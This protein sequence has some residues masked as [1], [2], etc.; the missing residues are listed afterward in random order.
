MFLEVSKNLGYGYNIINLL[1]IVGNFSDISDKQ[2][3]FDKRVE[4]LLEQTE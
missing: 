2:N 4:R 3:D 1:N